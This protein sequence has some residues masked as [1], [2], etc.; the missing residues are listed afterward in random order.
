[1]STGA[2]RLIRF[3]APVMKR[4]ATRSTSMMT[5]WSARSSTSVSRRSGGGE[6][7]GGS[8]PAQGRLA[9]SPAGRRA[10][11]TASAGA[12]A[13]GARAWGPLLAC[14]AILRPRRSRPLARP[15]QHLERRRLGA[16]RLGLVRVLPAR[17]QRQRHEDALDASARSQ[18]EAGAAVVHQVELD[19]AAAAQPLPAALAV[20]P[21]ARDAA[22]D[23][24]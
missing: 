21:R 5:G 14:G 9:V 22:L 13:G 24:R 18:P 4:S 10:R 23:E 1:M 11:R 20:A 12:L 15:A 3:G 16:S 2:S 7:G 8:G 17:Q 19:V 6:G